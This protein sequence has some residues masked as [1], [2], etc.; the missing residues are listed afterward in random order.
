MNDVLL[1][2]SRGLEPDLDRMIA[3]GERPR[4][5]YIAMSMVFRADLVDYNAARRSTGWVGNWLE[6]LGG[7]NLTLAWACFKRRKQYRVIFTDGE[8]V[9]IPLAFLLKL[10]NS[11]PR[12]RH[13]MIAHVL[14][15]GKKL[16]FFDWLGVQTHIDTFF[17]YAS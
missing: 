9:G 2:V 11:G 12:P 5:D 13:L 15:A 7:P 1:T 10:A 4:P 3:R 17:V 16:P 6:M 14:S 8:Q